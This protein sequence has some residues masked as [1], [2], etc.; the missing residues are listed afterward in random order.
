VVV[1]IE[2]GFVG[3]HGWGLTEQAGPSTLAEADTYLF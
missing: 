1:E 2:E 3:V